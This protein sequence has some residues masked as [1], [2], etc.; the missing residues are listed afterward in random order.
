MKSEKWKEA[1]SAV[2]TFFQEHNFAVKQEYTLKTGRRLDILAQKKIPKAFLSVIIEVKDWN[3]VSRKQE[4][5]FCKQI[6]N[7]IIHYALQTKRKAPSK[8]NWHRENEPKKELFLGILCLTKDAHFSFRK[9]SNH[10]IL[11]NKNIQGI[12]YREQIAENIGLYVARFD[13][14]PKVFEDFKYPL[15]KEPELTDWLD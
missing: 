3:N 13:F 2:A 11:K 4:M 6:I 1:Q 15:F 5:A 10:F 14:L 9:V 8:D 7:Y 12:P